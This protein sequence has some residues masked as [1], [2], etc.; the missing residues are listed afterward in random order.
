MKQ[1]WM[2]VL[3]LLMALLMLACLSACD[4]NEPP[5]GGEPPAGDQTPA[6]PVEL[7]LTWHFGYVASS[8]HATAPNTL[9]ENGDRYSYT[10]VFTVEKAGT[11]ITF[12][13]DNSNSKGDYR[14]ASE[15]AYVVSSWKQEGDAWVLDTMRANYAGN[16]GTAESPIVSLVENDAVTYSYTTY[17][18]NEHLRLCFRSGQKSNFTP[19][20]FP[21][22]TAEYTG[23]EGTAT[24]QMKLNEWIE[25]TKADHY[26]SALEGLTVNALGDSYFAGSG[27]PAHE[28]WLN[29]WA[30]KYGMRMNNYGIGGSTVSACEGYSNPMCVRYGNM[31]RN[32]VDIVIL[33]GGRNDFNKQAPIGTLESNDPATFMGAWNVLIDGVQTNYPDAMIVMISPWN[34]PYENGKALQREDY[35]GAMRQVAEAQGVY[36]IDASVKKDTGVDMESSMFRAEYCKNPNDVSHLNAEGMK[37]VMPHFDKLISACYTDFLAKK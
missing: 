12:T 19:A 30:Q 34:F 10:D 33:E 27:L 9:V 23:N 29:L 24:E 16:N 15:S 2:R 3:A 25:S 18:D 26:C 7:Q 6:G 32:N 20:A 28:I 4:E 17:Y 36:F 37:R 13:D 21:K 1:M 11:T 8:T 14:F 35:I 5:E 22:V 31:V